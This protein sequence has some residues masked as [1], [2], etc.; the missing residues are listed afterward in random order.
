MSRHKDGTETHGR[1]LWRG[2]EDI[3]EV[4]REGVSRYID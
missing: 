2:A 3:L 4:V 1:R